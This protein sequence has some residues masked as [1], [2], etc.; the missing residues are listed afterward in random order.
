[1]RC[2]VPRRS[3]PFFFAFAAAFAP[4][5]LSAQTAAPADGPDPKEIPVPPIATALGRLPGGV[6]A[7]DRTV[8]VHGGAPPQ[9]QGGVVGGY[10]CRTHPPTRCTGPRL[11]VADHDLHPQHA[12]R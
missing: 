10:C 1:M 4:A 5:A 2:P 12:G 6:A 3:L 7:R 9:G 8:G 11:Q